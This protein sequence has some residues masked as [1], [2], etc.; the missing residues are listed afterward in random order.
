MGAPDND[1]V[2]QL[3][4]SLAKYLR[5]RDRALARAS[6]DTRGNAE[7]AAYRA[8]LVLK[9]GPLRSSELADALVA[10]PSTVSRQVAQL[11]AE[12]L[13]RREADPDDGRAAHLVLTDAGRDKLAGL[14]A[15][16]R[17]L[18]ASLLADWTPDEMDTFV[19]LLDRFVA[20]V[21]SE[22]TTTGTEGDR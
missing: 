7:P 21:E 3:F 15:F 13:V 4:A 9:H 10:D 6:H 12:G 14:V 17:R 19:T 2:D 8:L 1:L 22:I 16:R 11:V 18:A 20:A 5:L